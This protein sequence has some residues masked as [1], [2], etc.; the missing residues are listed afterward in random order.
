MPAERIYVYKPEEVD[1]VIVGNDFFAAIQAI[2]LGIGALPLKPKTVLIE[3]YLKNRE[4]IFPLSFIDKLLSGYED[5]FVLSSIKNFKQKNQTQKGREGLSKEDLTALLQYE[6]FIDHIL[7]DCKDED[8]IKEVKTRRQGKTWEELLH[9]LHNVARYH[10]ADFDP[11]LNVSNV[12]TDLYKKYKN[13]KGIF[14]ALTVCQA[15]ADEEVETVVVGA[16]PI[17]LLNTIGL[18]SHHKGMKLVILEK[19]D[20]YK[21]NHTLHMDYTQIDKFLQ[22]SAHPQLGEDPAIKEFRDRVKKNPYIRISEVEHLLKNR[23]VELGA[24]L[25]TGRGITDVKSEILDKY[26]NANLILGADGTRSV[27]SQQIMGEIDKYEFAM[28]AENTSLE[29]NKIYLSLSEDRKFTYSMKALD[30]SEVRNIVTEI[31][32]PESYHHPDDLDHKLKLE[33]RTAAAR[34]YHAGN[35]IKKEF[36]FVL[37]F[38]FEV[39]G[40]VTPMPLATQVRFMQNYGLTCDEYV[41]KKDAHGKTPVT[42]QMMISKEHYQILEKFAKSGNPIM[43]FSGE[44]DERMEKVP[45]ILMQQLKGYL[46]LRLRHFTHEYDIVSLDKA[47]ISVNEAPATFANLTYKKLNGEHPCDVLLAGDAKLGLSYFKGINAGVEAS[48]AAFPS[49]VKPFGQRHEGLEQ[50]QTWF[51]EVYAPQKVREVHNYSVYRIGALVGLFKTLQFIFRSDL[52]MRGET[53]E[54]TVDLYLGHLKAIRDVQEAGIKRRPIAKPHFVNVIRQIDRNVKDIALLPTLELT[55]R[56]SD[57]DEWFDGESPAYTT[58]SLPE[59]T[60]AY[61]YDGRALESVL[62]LRPQNSVIILREIGKNIRESVKPYKSWFYALRD[63]MLPFRAIYNLLLGALQIVTALPVEIFNGLYGIIFPA[64][65]ETRISNAVTSIFSFFAR[66]AEGVS[67]IILG[68]NL[69]VSTVFLPLKLFARIISTAVAAFG[70]EPILIENNR[71]IKELVKEGE[72]RL[73][74]RKDPQE[75]IA[76]KASHEQTMEET[77]AMEEEVPP[78]ATGKHPAAIKELSSIA[79]TIHQDYLKYRHRYQRTNISVDEE[80]RKYQQCVSKGDKQSFQQ[81]FGLFKSTAVPEAPAS[82]EQENF[83]VNT[84]M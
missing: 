59:W 26:K 65:N 76:A 56:S 50:H 38:R 39:E 8:V 74:V 11:L 60:H 15:P 19:F 30:G 2:N 73:T 21:R 32:A 67:R 70:E 77:I 81:Y 72:S 36:D 68:I 14:G 61:E 23:A 55:S 71:K 28:A 83:R 29:E 80:K 18:L 63:V 4:E 1:Y 31:K 22:A 42:F 43:P 40:D 12:E 62:T 6:S 16:G 20:E 46:G 52:L 13:A 84:G 44:D 9:Y 58:P 24:H 41:G 33:L 51:Q 45:E 17:G 66:I 27:I 49:L 37:Q 10:G 47:T 64:G 35:T 69:A 34:N 82:V 53:A 7:K 79:L 75:K 3:T 54:K 25:I 57:S 48:A 78:H 5:E